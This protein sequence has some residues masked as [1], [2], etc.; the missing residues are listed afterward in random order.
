MNKNI[1]PQGSVSVPEQVEYLTLTKVRLNCDSVCEVMS[2]PLD[3]NDRKIKCNSCIGDLRIDYLTAL[4]PNLD[5]SNL[6]QTI[7]TWNLLIK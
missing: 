4:Q 7:L 1:A 6:V 5:S 3:D 2:C